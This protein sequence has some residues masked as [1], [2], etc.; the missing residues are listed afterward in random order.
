MGFLDSKE[1]IVDVILTPEGRRQLASGELEFVYYSFWDDEVDYDPAV[2]SSGSYSAD[3][4]A[5]IQ[6]DLREAHLVTE[7]SPDQF[8]STSPLVDAELTKAPLFERPASTLAVPTAELVPTSGSLSLEVTQTTK[9]GSF[10]RLDSAMLD[11][12]LRVDAPVEQLG[13]DF[14]LASSGS[15]GLQELHPQ[16]DRLGRVSLG[17]DVIV[18][19]G[20]PTLGAAPRRNLGR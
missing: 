18:S 1:R 19:T 12:S 5:D 4:L 14:R 10:V 9:G 15:D 17:P 11:V 7:A 16:R 13:S 8:L 2:L 3:A 6:R 20:R